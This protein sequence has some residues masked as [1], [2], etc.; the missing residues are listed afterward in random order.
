M[1]Q[2]WLQDVPE[3][4]KVSHI[5]V[6]GEDRS[7]T[8]EEN[9]RLATEVETHRD[10]LIA[11]PEE[12]SSTVS[13][14]A[15]FCIYWVTQ[16][17]E[18]D[19]LINTK[20]DSTL[21]LSRLV[22]A[23]GWLRG[24]AG[25]GGDLLYFGK[26]HALAKVP[27]PA[28]FEPNELVNTDMFFEFEYRGVYWPE[29]MDGGMYGISRGLA[30]EIVK[31]NFRTYTR[32]DAMVGVWVS[33]FRAETLYLANEQVLSREGEYIASNGS[34]VVAS[35][36]TD[37]LRL[38]SMWCEYGQQGTLSSRSVMALDVQQALDCLGSYE[39][40]TLTSRSLPLGAG[41][42]YQAATLASLKREWPIK[43]R[44]VVEETGE[45]WSRMGGVFHGRP[46]AVVGTSTTVDCLPL[47]L[48]QG[49]HTLVLD[50]FF[51]VSERYMSWAP[52]MYMCA[53]PVLCTS[54]GVDRSSGSRGAV[55]DVEGAN[56]FARKVFAAFYALDGAVDG[57]EYWRY[58]R[59][60]VNAHWF[61]AGEVENEG[62]RRAPGLGKVAGTDGEPTTTL[63]AVSHRSGIAMS[64]EVLSFLGFSPIYI[65]AA[66]EELAA[67]WE[68][69]ARAIKLTVAAYGTEVVYLYADREDKL[70]KKMVNVSPKGSG[71]GKTATGK[72]SSQEEFLTWTKKNRHNHAGRS[73]KWDLEVFLQHFPVLSRLEVVRGA[74]SVEAMFPRT[75]RCRD[76]ADLD[77]FQ[78]AVLCPVKIS[79]KHFSSFLS[80]HVPY[81][82][83]RGTFVWAKR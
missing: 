80:W 6:M 14:V 81:G 45:W 47:Y 55:T 65:T 75:P 17:H 12:S 21:F 23:E 41:D 70:P 38:A 50:D 44:P 59:Q 10:I 77:R 34:C 60:R 15:K 40:S 51:R 8:R 1:R 26:K 20:D 25:R 39:R 35:F 22:G 53:D 5:F 78:K 57:V 62:A 31:N 76:A 16:N 72:M 49:V 69:V 79:L 54:R 30:D 67:Q 32:E 11:P 7:F 37:L 61:V 13:E 33:S 19:I 56:R 64:L 9:A 71:G 63:R 46:A 24:L 3:G 52:T 58:L 36:H 28:N 68:E 27:N 4:A 83:V 48:L 42:K 18:F 2:T 73:T 66:N 43:D 82:P 74:S 29:F